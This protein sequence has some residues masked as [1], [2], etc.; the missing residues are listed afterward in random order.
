MTAPR[1]ALRL[2][3][4][5][6]IGDELMLGR[7]V[8]TNSAAIA[9]QLSDRGLVVDQMRQV[10]DGLDAIT[11]ALQTLAHGADLVICTGGLGPT[12]DDR[13]RAA[14]AGAI[15]QPLLFRETAWKQVHGW[16]ARHLPGKTVPEA[17][18]RQA[19]L[20]RGAKMLIN[21][22]GTAPGLLARH[23][24]GAWIAC[25][26]GVP[27]EMLAMA[28]RLFA[29]LPSL[30]PGLTVPAISEFAITGIGESAVQ[31]LI[32]GLLSEA[33]PMVG[34]TAH[35][36]G[37]LTLRAVGKPAA[38]KRR[39]N[40]LRKIL[41]QWLIPEPTVPSSLVAELTRRRMTITAA[42]SCTGGQVAAQLTAIPGSSRVLR[43][44]RVVYHPD[45]KRALGVPAAILR[46]HGVVSEQTALAMAESARTALSADIA[47]ATTGIA[48]PTGGSEQLPV[49]TV[50]VAVAD[51]RGAVAKRL[52]LSGSRTRIQLRAAAT[53]LVLAW[54]RLRQAAG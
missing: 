18:R 23:P 27:H 41:N 31:D 21:D 8:D 25:F 9:R 14:V 7:T 30:I 4:I 22:R 51:A 40:Q 45:A 28:D 47:V 11:S 49:G 6:A 39:I 43:E 52:R 1:N 5:L 38:V 37:H 10:G 20:P 48:G 16:Y 29:K 34:I 35:D 54:E 26:P 33:D 32:P 42:E 46:E 50:W 2:A 17:N 24:S 36:A 53:T 3:R 13:T 15:G 12:D 44:S 19:E